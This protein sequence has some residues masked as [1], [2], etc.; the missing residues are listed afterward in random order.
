MGWLDPIPP[1]FPAADG[2]TAVPSL[3]FALAQ[4]AGITPPDRGLL[5][6]FAYGPG[7]IPVYS[8][9]DLLAC[10]NAH[11]DGFFAQHFAGKS[12]ILAEMLDQ[13]DRYFTSASLMSV[14]RRQALPPSTQPRCIPS[15][16]GAVPI[17][18]A[19]R[20]KIPGVFVH[21]TALQNIALGTAI[22]PLPRLPSALGVGLIAF[23]AALGFYAVSP[24]IGAGAALLAI[25]L[26]AL[27]GALALAQGLLL[28]AVTAWVGIGLAY[29]V[30]AGDRVVLEQRNRQRVMDIFGAFLAPAVVRKLAADPKSLS[31]VRRS[32]TIMF[33]DIVGYTSLTESLKRE[34]DRLISLLNEYLGLL[35]DVVRKHGGYV[36]KFIGDA[37]LAVWNVPTVERADAGRAA[38]EA[39]LECADLV[40]AKGRA[41][42]DG[43]KVDVRIG[44][45]SGEVTGGLV[46]SATRVNYTVLG[47]A[48]NLASRLESSNKLFGT[49]MLCCDATESDLAGAEATAGQPCVRRRRLGNVQFKGKSE[50]I[51]VFELLGRPGDGEAESGD[52]AA[53]VALFEAGELTAAAA[54]FQRIV[55]LEP[56]SRIYLEQ[57]AELQRAPTRPENFMIILHEK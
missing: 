1:S 9:A 24:L 6:D 46:G 43:I 41:R 49:H 18:F 13:E 7:H 12:V 35:A 34:P 19:G 16:Q 50:G 15:A 4:R 8:L 32:A 3:A 17:S 39:A 47:D 11:K 22:A 29:L 27:A 2:K 23:A 25:L 28:P 5:V 52:F 54:A 51:G 45:A 14:G 21:A 48:V 42:E 30:T 26:M 56:P 44:I 57:I 40:R 53:A 36:D 20:W 33:I 38:T 31:P 55:E 10:A 37:V